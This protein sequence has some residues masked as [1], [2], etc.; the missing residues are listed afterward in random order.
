[1]PMFL[2]RRTTFLG[3]GASA[4]TLSH[5]IAAQDVYPSRAI[6]SILP[7]QAGS[8]SDVAVRFVTEKLGPTLG[9]NIVIEN[10]T[11]AAGL[12]GAERAA[13]STPDG[14]TLAALNNSI[15][16]IMPN[17]LK[18]KLA[19]DPMADFLPIGGISTIPTFLGVHKDV[20]VKT[21][22]EFKAYLA[23]NEGKVNYASGGP[24]SPQHLA[25][26][27]FMAMTGLKMTQVAYRGAS[28]AATD[29]AGGHVQAMFIALSLALPF[30]QG[31][32]KVRLLAFAGPERHPDY[33]DV[34]T[35]NEQ[36]VTGYDYSSWIALFALKGTP[37]PIVAKLRGELAKVL[38]DP[39]LAARMRKVGLGPWFKSPGDVS[40]AISE[41]D[42]RW[43]DVVKT[44][45]I[46]L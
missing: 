28:A 38:V 6:V 2:S 33:P 43:K 46:T 45:N 3:V 4:L 42:A 19:F 17:I 26:E 23:A 40:K 14:Y 21:Y 15:L 25:T 11:G 9:Q 29:L 24:G 8:A 20:P 32:A 5:P 30:L 22:A 35:L 31:D 41:D 27:M 16:T 12:V 44:A 36:G 7:L 13:K 37:E 34:P 10:V 39:E 18:K 1:M